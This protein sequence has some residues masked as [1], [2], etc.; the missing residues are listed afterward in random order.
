MSRNVLRFDTV[1]SV[2]HLLC[3]RQTCE[4]CD[5]CTLLY[6]CCYI[7]FSSV[8]I[9]VH[10]GR[11]QSSMTEGDCLCMYLQIYTCR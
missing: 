5:S 8:D 9:V 11:V 7:M 10:M 2:G 4:L 6:I 3:S 1:T